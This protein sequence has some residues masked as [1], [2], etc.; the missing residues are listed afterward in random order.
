MKKLFCLL[1]ILTSYRATAQIELLGVV[2]RKPDSRYLPGLGAM[3]KFGFPVGES[4]EIS[5]ELALRYIPEVEYPDAYGIIYT[6]VKL[7]YRYTLDRSGM[8]WYV[9]PQAGYNLYGIRS[10]QNLDGVDVDE[11]FKGVVGS[12]AFGYLFERKRRYA[13]DLSLR[14]ESVIYSGGTTNTIGIRF[15]R[16]LSFGRNDY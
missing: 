1:L 4:D 9:E 13:S 3:L 8:G 11:K 2:G 16:N 10:Y 14:F 15:T 12:I 5:A 6:P 7:G